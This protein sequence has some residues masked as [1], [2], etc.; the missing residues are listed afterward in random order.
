MLKYW[1]ILAL[2]CPYISASADAADG[3]SVQ[4]LTVTPD[5]VSLVGPRS[6]Q[7]LAVSANSGTAQVVDVTEDATFISA[8]PRIAIVE[9]GIVKPVG[10]GRTTVTVRVEKASREIDVS[11]QGTGQPS[12]V[13]FH[14]EV[15]SALTKAGCNMGACHGSPSGKGGFR[16]S[17]R[18]YDP[19]LDLLTLRGEF[20]GRRGNVLSPEESLLLQKPTM[21]VAH[22]GGQRLRKE[23]STYRI[24]RD[25]IADGMTIEPDHTPHLDRIEI[26]P[27]E[28]VFLDRGTRQ[29]LI[30]MGCFSDGSK[31]DLTDLTAFDSS[32]E[33][34]ATI[35]DSG[36]VLKEG[37]GE[38]T[39][40]GRVLDR[41]ATSRFT[42]LNDRAGFIWPNPR[43]TN[44]IDSLVYDKLKQLQILPSQRC[45]DSDF[46]RR[47]TLDLAG[48][49]PTLQELQQFNED[50]SADKRSHLIDRLLNSEDYASFWSMKWGDVLRCN[51]RRLTDSGAHK[52]RRWLF[53]AVNRDM[54]LDQFTHELL[55]AT[56]STQFN[57]AANYWRASRDEIDAVETTAQLFLG[58]RIQCAKCHN[59]PFEKWTQDDY[60]G[61]AAAFNRVGRKPD[62]LPDHEL[63]YVK[64]S[65]N[66]KQPRTGEVMQVR[67]L[68]Q[69]SVTVPDDQDRRRVFADWLTKKTNPFFAR[70]L[71]NRIWGH[72]MGRGIVE[73][74][75]DF[76]D[77][78]P[79][80]NAAL[81][82]YLTNEL[83][84]NG[85][86]ARHLIRIILNS[87]AYQRSTQQNE[88]NADDDRYFSH[89]A[90]RMLT[91]EQLLDSVCQLTGVMEE[92]PGLPSSTRA[93]DL[94][95]PPKEH[96]FLQVFGQ[97]Q[98]ELPC[99]CERSTDS[100]LS[101]ALQLI[102]GPVIHDKIRNEQGRLHQW[103][104]DGRSNEEIVRLLYQAGLSRQPNANELQIALKHIASNKDRTQ[105]LED[106]TW[107]VVNS[108]E[109]LFQ[110]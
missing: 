84:D 50:R 105:S 96:R 82:D 76:R 54:P 104:R 60:Y 28:R 67:L 61:V 40:L 57:P 51:S 66:V 32:D 25:W 5:A 63:I 1:S 58:I 65:G 56:G 59:H 68:L 97:P 52:F 34:V 11:V 87:Q 73:P 107:A 30:V 101:Q 80:S 17:L 44:T 77:S 14:T 29:Q 109:F 13:T 38:V 100:N 45:T 74:V 103:I 35:T 85:F 49:L 72:L 98:R 4:T 108:K 102:N 23:T 90:T 18:G 64:R 99:E 75:D 39:I 2:T 8:D 24:L 95:D 46:I 37:R 92:Y 79:P 71:A 55:T 31:R 89:A 62:D 20:Y 83:S 16:L 48:R 12:P 110:H 91:A 19:P 9:E 94:V 41:M 42:F 88:F 27:A 69:E 7:Q 10:D 47:V 26:L 36:V 43:V 81:L 22:G 106:I 70:S 15:L 78:N 21:E 6:R 33:S 86:S 3:N 93:I 53:D